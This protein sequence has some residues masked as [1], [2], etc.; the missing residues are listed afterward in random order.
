MFV[1][2]LKKVHAHSKCCKLDFKGQICRWAIDTF[3]C[4]LFYSDG[5]IPMCIMQTSF[6]AL[7]VSAHFSIALVSVIGPWRFY[8]SLCLPQSF[9]VY[10]PLCVSPASYDHHLCIVV[11][12]VSSRAADCNQNSHKCVKISHAR[13]SAGVWR[14]CHFGASLAN[15]SGWIHRS[16]PALSSTVLSSVL[17]ACGE[18]WWK[19][20]SV[21]DLL[22]LSEDEARCRRLFYE[23]K[24]ERSPAQTFRSP[25]HAACLSD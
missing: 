3:A 16:L 17:C 13:I 6:P 14:S 11:S 9:N 18:W 21:K 24:W 7:S 22:H 25:C 20:H 8:W 5:S 4:F 23:T 12:V 1:L 2:Q 19:A 10:H 15:Q